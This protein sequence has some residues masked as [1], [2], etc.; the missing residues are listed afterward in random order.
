MSSGKKRKKAARLFVFWIFALIIFVTGCLSPVIADSLLEDPG[1]DVLIGTWIYSDY[2]GLLHHYEEVTWKTDGSR[3]CYNSYTQST[4]SDGPFLIVERRIDAKG[5]LLLTVV[6]AG[7]SR[8]ASFFMKINRCGDRYEICRR[9][10]T[11]G[12]ECRCYFRK[13][14][15]RG[16]P[17]YRFETIRP[18]TWYAGYP[19]NPDRVMPCTKY[20]WAKA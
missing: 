18:R 20:F 11:G 9:T 4:R 1:F 2:D 7:D 8:S 5:C 3:V 6:E 10:D 14:V 15:Y 19:F 12:R 16:T 13:K 17:R